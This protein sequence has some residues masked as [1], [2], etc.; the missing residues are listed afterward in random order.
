MKSFDNLSLHR[1]LVFI[2]VL[3][4]GITML[5]AGSLFIILDIRNHLKMLVDDLTIDAKILARNCSAALLFGDKTTAENMLSTLEHKE[6][7]VSASIHDTDGKLFAVYS[8]DGNPE[9]IHICEEF[10]GDYHYTEGNIHVIH[11]IILDNEI[12]GAVFISSDLGAIMSTLIDYLTIGAFVLIGAGFISYLLSSRL[13]RIITNP[14]A[15]LAGTARRISSDRDFQVRAIKQNDDEVGYLVDAFNEMLSQL[16]ERDAALRSEHEHSTGIINGSPNVVIGFS[17]DGVAQFVNPACEEI[18]EYS[19][20]ELIGKP[21][22]DL[23]LPP[24]QA[25]RF[26][27]IVR[28][29]G[30]NEVRDYELSII[31]KSGK[32]KI[33]SMNSIN[34]YDS[35]NVL[36]EIIV[37]GNDITV[38]KQ[39]EKKIR[40][41]NE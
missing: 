11:D 38:K 17:P 30:K 18:L 2:I 5:T 7:I 4:S 21:L 32:T 35:D 23:L 20:E 12:I 8:R 25:R 40:K 3:I 6:S 27:R 16:Q 29:L 31:T 15:D 28:L 41:I 22:F 1:K 39:V 33:I 13:Q 10:E 14:I 9:N 19:P 34:S 24:D 37:L 36:K 26:A